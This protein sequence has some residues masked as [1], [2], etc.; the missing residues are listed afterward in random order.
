MDRSSRRAFQGTQRRILVFE[1]LLAASL[2]LC[3]RLASSAGLSANDWQGFLLALTPLA[4]A[5]MAQTFPI[6]AGG[7]GLSA[8]ATLFLVTG[9]VAT[10][11][12]IGEFD[13]LIA[14]LLG[15]ALGSL[16]GALN[17]LLI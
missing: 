10:W 7:Q 14:I 15:L 2:L 1:A 6:I 11:P 9:V 3:W 17:G 16:I 12:I 5:S 8:G 13:A 4:I